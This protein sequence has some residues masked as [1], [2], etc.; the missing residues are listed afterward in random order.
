MGLKWPFDSSDDRDATQAEID[1]FVQ[2]VHNYTAGLREGK[3]MARPTRSASEIPAG[4]WMQ[5]QIWI[6][7]KGRVLQISDIEDGHLENLIAWIEEHFLDINQVLRDTAGL[8]RMKSIAWNQT[9]LWRALQ[10]EKIRRDQAN[11]NPRGDLVHTLSRHTL[12]DNYSGLAQ[13]IIHGMRKLGWEFTR[14]RVDNMTGPSVNQGD[15]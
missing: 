8:K 10:K 5:D 12:V 3:K 9:P 4:V 7:G 6:D 2:A 14:V 1:S 15:Y 13:S 11:N